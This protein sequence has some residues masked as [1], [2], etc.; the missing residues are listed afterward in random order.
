MIEAG[1]FLVN[2]LFTLYL[3]ILG[4]RLILAWERANYFNPI[5]RFVITLTQP[6]IAPVRRILPNIGKLETATLFWLII[7]EIVKYILI[8][9]IMGQQQIDFMVLPLSALLAVIILLIQIFFYSILIFAVLSWIHSPATPIMQVLAQLSAPVLRPLQKII[10][11]VS[12]F[13]ITPLVAL[14][15]LQVLLILL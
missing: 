12:G 8:L 14:I 6:L 9:A 11:M 10:P 15:L 2:T 13:D 5:I 4:V 1:I 3:T 7:L